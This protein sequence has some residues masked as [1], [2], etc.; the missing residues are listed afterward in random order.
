MGGDTIKDGADGRGVGSWPRPR[1]GF[2]SCISC[3]SWFLSFFS[4]CVVGARV[5][6]AKPSP[7]PSASLLAN[8]DF[9]QADPAERTKPA[10]WDRPDGLGVQWTEAP[11]DPGGAPHGKAIRMD[12][13]V[14]EKAMVE[15]WRKTGLTQ[16]DIPKPANSA[17]AETYGLSYYSAPMPV[18]PG[19]AYR[20]SFDFKGASGGAKVWV[21][22]WGMF[23]GQ[24]RRRWETI[25][26]CHVKSN[27]WTHLSQVFQ[28]TRNRPEVTEM[29]VMLYAY[30]PAGV[31]WFDNVKIEPVA[32]S[33]V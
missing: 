33:G 23:N 20:V 19:Q 21:R 9:E 7:P 29:R 28:P 18:K 16:W 26:N 12:T 6:P 8:G 31:Y 5:A 10:G 24:K 30:Y 22:G 17:V 14:S 32:E 25:V 13:A 11:A 15:Q 27:Q 3:I 2:F 1:S 4:L